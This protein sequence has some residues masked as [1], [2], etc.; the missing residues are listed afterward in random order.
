M[1]NFQAITVG[2]DLFLINTIYIQKYKLAKNHIK[3]Y[4]RKWK[5]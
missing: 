4:I 2:S 3:K 1:S 5:F